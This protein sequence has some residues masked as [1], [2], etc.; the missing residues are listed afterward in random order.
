MG[1]V[2]EY[3]G[4]KQLTISEANSITVTDTI[5]LEGTEYTG[6]MVTFI[7]E[8]DYEDFVDDGDGFDREAEFKNALA[9]LVVEKINPIC[10]EINK[11][12]GDKAYLDAIM[13]NGKEKAIYVADSVLNKVYDT[14]G[15]SKT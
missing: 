4:E 3:E 6:L 7:I 13:K 15:F 11:L 2:T 10:K 9:D 8:A 5:S 14:V 12:M 1:S